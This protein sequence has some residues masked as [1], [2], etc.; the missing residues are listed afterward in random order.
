MVVIVKDDQE[1]SF[2]WNLPPGTGTGSA[3]AA[4]PGPKP[5]NLRSAGDFVILTKS[6]ITDVPTSAVTGDVGTSPITG[7]AD[8]LTC[9]EVD[10]SVFSVNAAGPE[11]CR[12][13]DPTKLTTAVLDMETA[14]EDAAGRKDP[15]FTNWERGDIGG[16][17][18]EPGLYKWSSKCE[19]T[20]RG[21]PFR[22]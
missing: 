16:L 5:V 8:L 2:H 12:I 18:L 20:H 1:Y 11:P 9:T 21:H 4:G 13:K 17:T 3:F 7:A 19:S 15:D 22:Q 10:G 6:G 14:Y